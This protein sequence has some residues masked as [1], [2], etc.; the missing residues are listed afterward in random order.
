MRIGEEDGED[1]RRAAKRA[2]QRSGEYR[3]HIGRGVVG[4]LTF[5]FLAPERVILP[6]R[7]SEICF[8]DS[9]FL[10]RNNIGFLDGLARL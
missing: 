6:C 2:L 7:V 10:C 3:A 1:E 9:V 5:C 8:L 4:S